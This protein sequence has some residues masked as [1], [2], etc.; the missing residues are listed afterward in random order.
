MIIP[1]LEGHSGAIRPRISFPRLL[2]EK[3]IRKP[4]PFF[5]RRRPHKISPRA[6]S[7]TSIKPQCWRSR[8]VRRRR[9]VIKL[10]KSF[11]FDPDEISP[12]RSET[13]V[14]GQILYIGWILSLTLPP[15]DKRTEASGPYCLYPMT[16]SPLFHPLIRKGRWPPEMRGLASGLFFFFRISLFHADPTKRTPL[17]IS[18]R[19]NKNQ[20]QVLEYL[21]YP[22]LIVSSSLSD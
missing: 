2:Q 20:L 19:L 13:V 18:N 11:P 16:K 14:L 21:K 15:R 12:P 5:R 9:R 10:R 7:I 22:Y 17:R 6:K 1:H 8:H 4:P 3:T